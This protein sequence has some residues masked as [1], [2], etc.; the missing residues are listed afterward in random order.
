M[1]ELRAIV[2]R[3]HVLTGPRATRAYRKGY[4]FGGG[5]VAAVL[6]PGSLVALWRSLKLCVEADAIVVMQ[7]ANTG[8]T[9]GSTPDGDTYDRPVV[10]IN[11]GRIGGIHLLR[12][13]E[14]VICLPGATLYELEA[15]LRPIGREPH[16]VIGSSCIG[17][18]VVGGVCN[19][20][21]GALVRRGPAYTELSLYAQ[22]DEDGTL[23]LVNRLG[24]DL[25][26][27]PEGMLECVDAGRF[28]AEVVRDD[29]RR[30]ASDH[31]YRDHVRDVEAHTPAR[32][33]ADPH[34]LCDASGSAGRIVVFAVRLDT[35]IADAATTTFYLGTNDPAE[36]TILRRHMLANFA[37]LPVSAEYIHRTAFDLAALYGRDTVWAI[38]R[39]GTARLPA[40][41]R[42]K[43]RLDGL[44]RRL[45]GG[46]NASDRLLQRASRWLPLHLPRRITAFRDAYEHHLILKVADGGI[47]EARAY[48]A[49]IWSSIEG[50]WFECDAEEAAKAFLHRFAVA[51]AAVRYQAVHSDGI[52]GI[53]AL[54]V[55]LP[56]NARDW[57]ERLPHA[58][59]AQIEHKLYYGHFFC[60]VFHQD[61]L[62]RKGHDPERLE[63]ALLALL[64][65]RQAKYPAEHNVGQVYAAE[66]ALAAF[67][68]DLDPRNQLN[69]GIGRTSKLRDWA[70]AADS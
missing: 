11:T 27:G 24:I 57:F 1:A 28:S 10:L 36:L 60:H 49:S 56:R 51:G 15:A 59:E 32:F 23:R 64:D 45:G 17:A 19:N 21:G 18:S 31:A 63:H 70:G 20:S 9:G 67:Y 4:R 48:L 39:M 38:E 58:L 2:G 53:V 37:A 40:L 54:D 16:S 68:R 6:R 47:S 46:A 30:R 44:V 29:P 25:P 35:F 33:N 62:V 55:A 14:Q 66:P 50:D 22:L 12:G 3:R 8:L 26:D 42:W 34:R 41:F 61:Y 43:R 69:P 5:P 13:G 7:A 52:E 65:E